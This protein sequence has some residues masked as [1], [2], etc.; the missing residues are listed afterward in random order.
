[1]S[2]FLIKFCN[3]TKRM[4]IKIPERKMALGKKKSSFAPKSMDKID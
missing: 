1:M 4:S 2:T 3:L